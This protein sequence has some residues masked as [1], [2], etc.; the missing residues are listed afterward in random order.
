[1]RGRADRIACQADKIIAASNTDLVALA[2]AFI[3]N[4]HWAWHA[5]IELG[6]EVRRP[7]QYRAADPK[8][9]PGAI[10]S[11]ELD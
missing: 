5:A 4:P 9:W 2:R 1:L 8:L 7:P 6:G 10:L 3:D 11:H